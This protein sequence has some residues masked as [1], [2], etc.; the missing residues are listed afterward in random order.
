VT[1]QNSAI[2]ERGWLT[3]TF[4]PEWDS[5]GEL[6]LLTLSGSRADGI[7]V[8]YSEKP[9]YLSGRLWEN[10]IPLGQDVL[11]QY[12]CVAGL[13]RTFSEP[14]QPAASSGNP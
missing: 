11:F 2:V 14:V 8:G 9:E 3:V 7:R 6:Y 12:G 5:A 4:P 10:A 13:Q 1:Y